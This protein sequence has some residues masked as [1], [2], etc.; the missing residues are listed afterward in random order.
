MQFTDICCKCGKRIAQHDE[1][2]NIYGW[3][4]QCKKNVQILN[5]PSLVKDITTMVAQQVVKSLSQ[6]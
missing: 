2:G 6:L 5:V 3:C 1:N 4:K